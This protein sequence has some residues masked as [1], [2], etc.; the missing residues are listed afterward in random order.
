MRS[1]KLVGISFPF[2]KEN[3]QFPVVDIDVDAIKSDLILL[4]NTPI[5]SRVM[6]PDFGTN[7]HSLLFE[8]TDA[9]FIVRIKRSI[10]QTILNGAPNVDVL[11]LSVV[12]QGTTVVVNIL[13]E[14]KGVRDS[15]TMKI[16]A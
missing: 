10:Q 11:D 2:R 16:A 9:L 15:L 1:S 5:R 14:V 7:L 13:Y 4:F 3:N 12:I 6:R 8:S